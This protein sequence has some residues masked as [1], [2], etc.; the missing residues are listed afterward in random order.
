MG[1][2]SSYNI[3][4]IGKAGWSVIYLMPPPPLPPLPSTFSSFLS[5]LLIVAKTEAPTKFFFTSGCYKTAL[6]EERGCAPRRVIWSNFIWPT[7][8]SPTPKVGQQGYEYIYVL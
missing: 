1:K 6:T 2:R 4:E 5:I 3:S 8:N 7:V